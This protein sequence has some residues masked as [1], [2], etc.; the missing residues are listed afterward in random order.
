MADIFISYANEDRK[1]AGKLAQALE[2]AGFSVWWDRRIP[3]GRS[4]RSVLEEALQGMR[5]LIVLWSTNSIK[6]PWVIEEAEEARRLEKIMFPVLLHK[7]D[8]PV[9]FRAIQAANLV[10]WDGAADAPTVELLVADL[11]ALLGETKARTD[12]NVGQDRAN[13]STTG[14]KPPPHP[15]RQLIARHWKTLVSGCAASAL[16]LVA[17]QISWPSRKASDAPPAKPVIEPVPARHLT[18]IAVVGAPRELKPDDAVALKLQGDYSDGTED[19]IANSIKWTSSDS[20]VAAVDDQ[21]QLKALQ[22]GTAEISARYGDLVSAPWKV[23]VIAAQKV[24][25][26]I[27]AVRMVTLTI[28][29]PR[30]ELFAS[31]RVSLRV[32]GRYSDQSEKPVA[33]DLQW[34][35]SDP[36]IAAITSDGQLSG[37]RAGRVDVSVRTGAV[38][39]APIPI[40]VKERPKKAQI[41]TLAVKPGTESKAVVPASVEPARPRL[42]P[43]IARAKSLREQGQYAGALAELQRAAAI[44]PSNSEVAKEIE[45]TRKACAAEINLGQ[46]VDC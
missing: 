4:W 20:R 31:E 34:Q 3:A 5:C 11:K 28:T 33:R 29:A 27:P 30:K 10:D 19:D 35:I 7:I 45:Q 38:M 21:G 12:G 42:A 46:R 43:Y 13:G 6:S 17:L 9:G 41:E 8:P 37:L 2:S 24:V 1:I 36:T 16:L 40:V 26:D 18:A 14:D 15:L 23:A 44:D 39:S 25:K 32:L 22:P